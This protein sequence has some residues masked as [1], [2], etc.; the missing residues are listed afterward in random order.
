MTSPGISNIAHDQWNASWL[1]SFTSSSIRKILQHSFK[2][3]NLEIE[4]HG[5][6][7]AATSFLYG[8]GLPEVSKEKLDHNDPHYE[9][10][11]TARAVK[12]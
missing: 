7:Y 2:D 4:S 3:E 12:K 8:M 10:I 11:I 9:V 1:W 5:N 6:V